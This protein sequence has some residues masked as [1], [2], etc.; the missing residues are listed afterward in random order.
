MAEDGLSYAIAMRNRVLRRTD[1][2]TRWK[3]RGVTT[4][5]PPWHL[6]EQRDEITMAVAHA[7]PGPAGDGSKAM[8]RYSARESATTF[9][10]PPSAKRST[11]IAAML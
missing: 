4:S 7:D 11:V 5:G 3:H 8:I 9:V 2:P 6:V 1:W 10:M